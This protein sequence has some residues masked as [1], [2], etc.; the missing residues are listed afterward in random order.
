M[1]KKLKL[2]SEKE[3]MQE[4]KSIMGKINTFPDNTSKKELNN[5]LA[6]IDT[7][8]AERQKFYEEF[9]WC[10]RQTDATKSDGYYITVHVWQSALSK[11][12]FAD[13]IY[14]LGF[15]GYIKY[16]EEDMGREDGTYKFDL[17]K[18]I[19]SV[20]YME[21]EMPQAVILAIE[22]GD[23]H[24]FDVSHGGHEYPLYVVNWDGGKPCLHFE[25]GATR[26]DLKVVIDVFLLGSEPVSENFELTEGEKVTARC[27]FEECDEI[28]YQYFS[29]IING[30]KDM[31]Y[32]EPTITVSIDQIRQASIREKLRKMVYFNTFLTVRIADA[33]LPE[34]MFWHVE[35]HG[36]EDG[37]CLTD[38]DGNR[39][40]EWGFTE[41]GEF[42]Y[43]TG[44][45]GD[46]VPEELKTI[47]TEINGY[48]EQ[49]IELSDTH[50]ITKSGIM[51]KT[52]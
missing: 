2:M 18:G 26:H 32:L 12:Q 46:E 30:K 44:N 28:D 36:D 51:K 41:Y 47:C 52:A 38:K 34:G 25:D 10:N 9:P 22:N 7:E 33:R 5:R 29:S 43:G 17:F 42:Y 39:Y 31:S 49:L 15:A 27:D 6:A 20:R 48:F 40:L 4:K 50:D 19:G 45:A 1:K 24:G 16:P 14:R 8:L 13:V 3:L 21:K 23:S 37:V 35:Y 11:D